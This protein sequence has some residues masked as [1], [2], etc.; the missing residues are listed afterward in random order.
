MLFTVIQ[1]IFSKKSIVV[2]ESYK[3]KVMQSHYYHKKTNTMKTFSAPEFVCLLSTFVDEW[4]ALSGKV[5][6]WYYDTK[7]DKI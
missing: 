3:L 6:L 5:D 7:S 2:E 1:I 4:C